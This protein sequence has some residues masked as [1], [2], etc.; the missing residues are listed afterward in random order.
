MPWAPRWS[1]PPE[2]SPAPMPVLTLMNTR[3]STSGRWACCSPSA[4][5]FTSLSMSTGTS[6]ARCTW[7]GTSYRSQPGMIGGLIARP[8]ECSTGPGRPMPMAASSPTPGAGRRAARRSPTPPSRARASGPVATS[9]SSRRSTR[10]VPA[11]SARAAVAWV[12]P[13]STPGDHPGTGVQCEQRGRAAAGGHPAVRHH[14][15]E[16]QQRVDPRGDGR[17]GE[18][19]LLRELGA[20]PGLPVAQELEEITGPH[21]RK[22]TTQDFSTSSKELLP[23]ARQKCVTRVTV[24]P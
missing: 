21:V 9:R 22:S 16:A 17:A 11:R 6:K 7:A 14:Q 20:R 10:T 8:V 18:P 15:A 12:A 1:S 23:I 19:G 4:M 5:M 3:S 13:M 24:T 2:M